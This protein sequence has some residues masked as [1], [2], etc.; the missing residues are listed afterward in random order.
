M[1]KKKKNNWLVIIIFIVIVLVVVG[2]IIKNK[3]E[4]K[5]LEVTTVKA[6]IGSI[7][8]SVSASGKIHPE[9]EVKI[10]PDVPGEIIQLTV[11]EGDSVVQGQLLCR[12]R[13][14]NYISAVERAEASVNNSKAAVEQVRA[15]LTQAKARLARAQQDY[16]RNQTLFE[17]KVIAEADWEQIK[18]NLDV[19]KQDL[20]SAEANLEAS[21]FTI[22]S[23]EAGYKDAVENLRKTSI[24]APV[25]GIVSKLA[26]EL[27]ERVVG[28]SQMAGTEMMRIANLNNMEVRVDVNEN[29]IIR[30]KKGD[31]AV[32]D[33][34]AY[35]VSG[36]KFK[37]I[38]TEIANT[39][40]ETATADAVTEFQVKVRILSESYEDLMKK[41]TN[42][43]KS[44]FRPGMTASLDVITNRKNSIVLV[45]MAA[46]TTRYDEKKD[47]GTKT[48]KGGMGVEDAKVTDTKKAAAVKDEK[49]REVVFIINKEGKAEKRIVKTGISDY[50]NIEI[51]EG[52]KDGE[53]IISGPFQAVS[54]EIE[55]DTKVFVKEETKKTDK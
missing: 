1:A 44:P 27:G 22:N 10:T 29:D 45:P 18:T 47:D 37:G 33:V 16:N 4:D 38:V 14:D 25:S 17:Q 43:E 26:I 30:I 28:T 11:K 2:L 35:S 52:L 24:Y 5:G 23:A 3:S 41:L 31:S 53:E 50:E 8:E 54:K 49:P 21:K 13:P 12:I 36:K 51:V 42:K 15:G 39:A 19:A 9:V 34:D 20:K 6:K 32:I 46:V 55:P 48:V 7:T 40:K